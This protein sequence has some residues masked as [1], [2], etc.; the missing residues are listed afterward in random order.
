MSVNRNCPHGS[1]TGYKYSNGGALSRAQAAVSCQL[2]MV[3]QLSWVLLACSRHSGETEAGAAG[4]LGLPAELPGVPWGS[5]IL[6]QP[7]ATGEGGAHGDGD[8]K[9]GAQQVWPHSQLRQ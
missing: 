8:G 9:C 6:P 7:E 2:R 3:R 4:G 1:H 5:S